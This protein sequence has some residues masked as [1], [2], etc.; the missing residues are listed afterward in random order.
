MM[1]DSRLYAGVMA[2]VLFAASGA[3]GD[4]LNP[5]CEC[6]PTIS[7]QTVALSNEAGWNRDQILAALADTQNQLAL[8]IE[9][10]CGR[11]D[12]VIANQIEQTQLACEKYRIVI[13]EDSSKFQC[14]KTR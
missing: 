12:F 5:V 2:V 4:A 6:I 14:V 13:T 7:L 1:K 10:A 8:T 3:R 11:P 9:G